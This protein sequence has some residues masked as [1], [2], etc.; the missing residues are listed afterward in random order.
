M[1]RAQKRRFFARSRGKLIA[2]CLPESVGKY[3]LLRDFGRFF[4]KKSSGIVNKNAKILR[5]FS[6]NTVV[7]GKLN[8]PAKRGFWRILT[9]C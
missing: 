9:T 3:N 4:L 1:Q 5:N 8:L 7:N 6:K 2:L